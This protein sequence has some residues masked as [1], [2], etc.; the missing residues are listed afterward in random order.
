MAENFIEGFDD[1]LAL[2]FWTFTGGD[3]GDIHTD[4]GRNGKG[5]RIGDTPGNSLRHVP[6]VSTDPYFAVGFACKVVD[7]GGDA[8]KLLYTDSSFYSLRVDATTER[9]GWH[10]QNYGNVWAANNSLTSNTWHYIEFYQYIH[11]SA[12][13]YEIKVDGSTVLSNTGLDTNYS[14]NYNSDFVLGSEVDDIYVDDL[15]LQSGTSALTLKGDIEVVTLLPNG[16]G[17]SSDLLGSD[18]NSTDNYLLVDNNAAI[19]PSTTE[20]VGSATAGNKDTYGMENLTGTPTVLAVQTSLYASMTDTGPKQVRH[21]IRSGSTDYAGS[22]FALQNSVYI[23]YREMNLVDPDT[24]TAWTYTGVN[25]M[26]F[27]PEVRT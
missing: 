3:S 13:F 11:D 16:N 8:R 12:G 14:N 1:G 6:Q 10:N 25:S 4:Y 2:D 15:W 20:Y 5:V 21:V 24:S 26:E 27:G 23:P 22:D 18:S 17:N 9:I 7:Y 19:P